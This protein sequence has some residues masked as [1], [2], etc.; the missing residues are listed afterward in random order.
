VIQAKV[1]VVM[2]GWCGWWDRSRAG[3]V[4]HGAL[5]ASRGGGMVHGVSQLG[6]GI[7]A[8]S[9]RGGSWGV[10]GGWEG[11]CGT[12]GHLHISSF[13]QSEASI[14]A[15]I[16][17]AVSKEF[18][19]T[20]TLFRNQVGKCEGPDG[21]WI[22]YGL[23]PGSSDLVGWTVRDGCAI[24]TCIEVK[25]PGGRLR[26]EQSHWLAVVQAAGGIAGVARSAEEALYILRGA[27]THPAP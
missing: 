27:T 23:P 24:F 26:K 8:S 9:R 25:A 10:T 11:W 15:E 7:P 5:C 12:V 16:R 21:Q 1:Q 22:S 18:G 2:V 20:V 4:G 19:A 3:I 13:M 17:L 6:A 14:Q